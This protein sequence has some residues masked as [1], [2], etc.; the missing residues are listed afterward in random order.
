MTDNKLIGIDLDNTLIDYE[1]VFRAF[2]R[3]SGL[4]APGFTGGK[5]YIREVARATPDGDIAWQRLQGAVYSRGIR[6]AVMFDGADAFLRQARD[7]GFETVIV[8]HKTEFGHF[9]PDRINLRR[10]ALEWLDAQGFFRADGFGMS[11]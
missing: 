10:A 7:R 1:E 4:I 9:D 8:S 3:D 2:A 11:E 5:E 6:Q